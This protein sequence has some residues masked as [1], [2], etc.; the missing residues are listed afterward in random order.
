MG[1]D[2]ETR[3]FAGQ[4]LAVFPTELLGHAEAVT[5]HLADT[6][7]ESRSMLPGRG[8]P[9]RQRLNLTIT[10]TRAVR[11]ASACGTAA[12]GCTLSAAAFVECG[13][14]ANAWAAC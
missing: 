11:S 8:R 3:T 2:R 6:C 4:H 9:R 1:T 5:L 7:I 14:I 10:A 12:R 13:K